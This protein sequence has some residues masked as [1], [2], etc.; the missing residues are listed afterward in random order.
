MPIMTRMRDSMPVI[1]FGLLIA[2]LITIIFEWGMDYLG[3]S[4]GSSDVVGEV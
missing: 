3:L 2:F 1:L 4:A